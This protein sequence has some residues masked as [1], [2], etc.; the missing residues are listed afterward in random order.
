MELLVWKNLFCYASGSS[1]LDN[2]EISKMNSQIESENSK[3][4]EEGSARPSRSDIAKHRDKNVQ[5]QEKTD[6]SI[7]PRTTTRT[8]LT[9]ESAPSTISAASTYSGHDSM[10]VSN[11]RNSQRDLSLPLQIAST[12]NVPSLLVDSSQCRPSTSSSS[13]SLQ[14]VQEAK[15]DTL[16]VDYEQNK[17]KFKK[18]PAKE[19]SD[20]SDSLGYNDER[21]EEVEKPRQKKSNLSKMLGRKSPSK[22]R[23]VSPKESSV[24]GSRSPSRSPSPN[25]SKSSKGKV[26]KPSKKS[27]SPR[28]GRRSKS[29]KDVR[30]ARSPVVEFVEKSINALFRKRH[31]SQTEALCATSNSDSDPQKIQVKVKEK[32][33]VDHWKVGAIPDDF[34][35]VFDVN[36]SDTTCDSQSTR[37]SLASMDSNPLPDEAAQIE[38][39][40]ED[41]NDPF[42]E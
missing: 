39:H 29:P 33:A 22:S 25:K 21:S 9:P 31:D 36:L 23:E 16:G 12:P 32:K 4:V 17:R 40:I 15:K 30:R 6:F 42:E 24:K 8:T 28:D 5:I 2:F 19:K 14:L 11:P 20:D 34:D 26:E 13:E 10:I 38:A 1:K 18:S 37:P 35:P 27:L 3:Q 7:N 41:S